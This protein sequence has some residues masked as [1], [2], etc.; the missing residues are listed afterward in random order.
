MFWRLAPPV[1]PAAALTLICTALAVVFVVVIAPAP[2]IVKASAPAPS[3]LAV[4]VRVPA[5]ALTMSFKVTALREERV[6]EPAPILVNAPVV[7]L[8]GANGATA[9]PPMLNE[10]LPVP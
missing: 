9:D 5:P 3:A 4:T 8:P 10:M 6:M 7:I 2:V 1:P